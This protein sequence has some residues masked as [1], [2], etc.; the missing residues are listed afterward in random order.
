LQP[1]PDCRPDVYETLLENLLPVAGS[2]GLRELLQIHN[3]AL[4]ASEIATIYNS[5]IVHLPSVDAGDNISI[6][7][8]DVA[9]TTINGTATDEDAEDT[10]TYRWR[11][12]G[13]ILLNWT[14]A[15]PNGECRLDLSTVWLGIGTHTLTLEVRDG[16][17]T[18]PDEMSL[19]IE[20][21]APHPAINM[22]GTFEVGTPIVLKG[23]A[24]DYDGD[25]LSYQWMEGDR[26]LCSP[27]SIATSPNG[28]V[29]DLPD[30]LLTGLALGS[31]TISLIV[32]D[33]VNDPVMAQ[34]TVHVID[35]GCPTLAPTVTKAIL[36]PPN[37]KMVG[38]FIQ[39]NAADN[40]S[41]PV[42]LSARVSSNEPFE[43]LDDDDLSPDWTQPTI[44]Q[45]TGIISLQL[46]AE[47]SGKGNGRIYTITITA[48][49]SSQNSSAAD[50]QVIVPHDKS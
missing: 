40:S 11:Q 20:N 15:G 30:C 4:S 5:C 26:T 46:R 48:T 34:T 31:H 18:V 38:I 45:D 10:L 14:E 39:A 29:I 49:D 32:D 47:R 22:S 21:S 7:S 6:R 50:I 3:Y 33:G 44:N 25:T 12:G 16:T 1:T 9:G 43:G 2:Q 24:W 19:T 23:Q 36:W 8:E 41:Q 28:A 37:H 27:G 17:A 13:N 35:T 42:T